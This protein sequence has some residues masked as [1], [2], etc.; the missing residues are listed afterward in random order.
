VR[1]GK[2]RRTKGVVTGKQRGGEETDSIG[3][4]KIG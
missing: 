1:E 3:K 2:E 4:K